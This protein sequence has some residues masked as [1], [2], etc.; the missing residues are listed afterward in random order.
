MTRRERDIKR[1]PARW[2]HRF[3]E[4]LT[5]RPRLTCSQWAERYRHLG[6]ESKYPG[7]WLNSRRPYLVAPM[8]AFSNPRTRWVVAVF[9]AQCGKTEFENNCLGYAVTEDPGPALIAFPDER[10]ADKHIESRVHPMV[11]Q[12]PEIL[13]HLLPGDSLGKKAIHFDRM[14]VYTSWSNSPMSMSSTPYR[15]VIADEVDSFAAYAGGRHGSPLG[16][17]EV[18]T[19]TFGDMAKILAVGT[20]T[21]EGA[22]LWPLF[23]QSTQRQHYIPCAHCGKYLRLRWKEMRWPKDVDPMR[24]QEEDLA[25]Y[26]CPHCQRELRA[27]HRPKM[28]AMGRWVAKGQEV[29]EGGE[30]V[31]ELPQVARDGFQLSALYSPDVSWGSAA[32]AWLE[33]KGDLSSIHAFYNLWLGLP[34]QTR[35]EPVTA[36]R[37]E[38]A[39]RD[40][41]LGEVPREA[42]LL[43]CG[44]DVQMD[45]FW[46]VVRA[47]GLH[48]RSWLVRY[49]MALSFEELEGILL[50]AYPREGGGGSIHIERLGID[51]G[52]RAAEVYKWTSPRY[53]HAVPTR[54]AD[55]P[56]LNVSLAPTYPEPGVVCFRFAANIWKDRVAILLA[57]KPGGPG[58]WM[59]PQEVEEEYLQQMTS[60]HKVYERKGGRKIPQWVR[61]TEGRANHLW[62]CEVIAAV[63]AELAHVR[64][65]HMLD[66]PPE[67][68]HREPQGGEER[69]FLEGGGEW[70]GGGEG[71]GEW[72]R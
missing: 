44:V 42:R 7:P 68:K 72:F 17:L 35:T 29:R 54:G 41:K 33:A 19:R 67:P 32:R 57:S 48:E 56:G 62:D 55:T 63:M 49:G 61:R 4:A 38:G 27:P 11:R 24:I 66:A 40:Y 60:E 21:I 34:F 58:E 50:S 71:G 69:P 1:F 8:D 15:Y 65:L 26:V 53:P 16:H 46:Y 45:H 47:W 9:A 3:S 14:T 22:Y 2:T 23:L 28:L 36:A 5:P 31:G 37:L 59:I 12:S 70:F 18:R 10:S 52:Y 30:V 51:S 6:G 39:K 13:A 64:F 43:T 20:P 25:W